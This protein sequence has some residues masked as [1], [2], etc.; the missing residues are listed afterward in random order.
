MINK[1]I[2]NEMSDSDK[3]RI[4]QR[5]QA[6]Y[7][8]VEPIVRTIIDEV[9]QGGDSAIVD[10]TKRIDKIDLEVDALK[11]SKEEFEIAEKEISP[12]LKKYLEDAFKNINLHHKEQLPQKSWQQ[13]NVPGVI[14]GEKTTPIMSVGLYVPRGKGSFPSVMLMLCTPA[15]IAGVPDIYVCTPP[16]PD[17]S[18]D[19]AS[20]VAA[21]ICGIEN[22]YKVGGAQAMAALAYGTQTI[23]KVDKIVG[24]GNQY[25]S[26]AKRLVYGIVDPGLPAGPSE[27]IV[28]CDETADPEIVAREWLNEAE[29]G[30]D[31][32]ALLV[33]N[34]IELIGKVEKIVPG[35]IAQL[36]QERR[37]FIETGLS[38]Y[39]GIIICS[40]FEAGIDFVNEYAPEHLRIISK[41]ETEDMD[42]I[43]NAGEILVGSYSSIS[44]GN[45]AI[46][47][48]AILPT[49]GT[50]RRD[51]CV[52]VETFLKRSS[53][54]I[55]SAQG[56][57]II[58][59]IAEALAQWE[60]FPGHKES[61]RFARI[62][63][64]KELIDE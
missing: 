49:G 2:L 32:A 8:R 14:V 44:Y 26:C 25:V 40:D 53:F 35:L 3:N 18:I 13:E 6:D 1:F 57:V 21:R 61:A 38:T 30:P 15:V 56:A 54:S 12:E 46:G 28:L 5:A 17:G 31:S 62:K 34:S 33:T 41:N 42:K 39:G 22:V 63:A 51:S 29:H 20:L 9:R 16:G 37:N 10:I 36:T 48:N 7:S 59:P 4:M 43:I 45:F 50:A 19:A 52:G 60:G 55:V 47:L 27:S 64:E 24:P 58:S 11:V 23:P